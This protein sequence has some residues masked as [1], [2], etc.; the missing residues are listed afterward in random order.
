MTEEKPFNPDEYYPSLNLA[1]EVS[2]LTYDWAIRR[3][4]DVERRIDNLLIVGLS[5]TV[6]LPIIAQATSEEPKSLIEF[7]T[8]PGILAILFFMAAL[9][10]GVVARQIGHVTL[11]NPQRLYEGYIRK[12]QWDFRRHIIYYAGKTHITNAEL[13]QT[14]STYANWAAAFFGSEGLFGAIWILTL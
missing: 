6:A 3:L 2:L 9:F 5:G 8:W 1:Y 14:K 12:E 11:I 10:M 7:A 13:I 4:Q